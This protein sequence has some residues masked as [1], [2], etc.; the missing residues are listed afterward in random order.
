MT[1]T[2]KSGK[3]SLKKRPQ[4]SL[5]LAESGEQNSTAS[6]RIK[7]KSQ[8]SESESDPE[9]DT[10]FFENESSTEVTESLKQI[11]TD[12]NILQPLVSSIVSAV[13]LTP[14]IFNPLVEAVTKALSKDIAEKL[15]ADLA[16]NVHDSVSVDVHQN[17]KEVD[18]LKQELTTLKNENTQLEKRI[19]D[20]EQYSRR[21]CLLLHGV[22]EDAN[23]D[24]TAVVTD[25]IK[26]KLKIDIDGNDFDRTHRLGRVNPPSEDGKTR[27][28]PIIMRFIS[29]TDRAAVYKEKRHMK[30]S[31]ML[32]S[33]NLTAKRM[34]I[35]RAAY[36]MVKE[37]K[38]ANVWTQDGRI[39]VLTNRKR[40]VII[41]SLADL[42]KL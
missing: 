36:R 4:E 3:L 6:Q 17:M 30:H 34:A 21:N 1:M 32:I 26:K 15:K 31:P 14:N 2:S 38:I 19:D 13:L 7:T 24:T 23:E 29:Y 11:L 22:T 40:K 12:T 8:N 39:T 42:D 41:T 25:I 9:H 28:R 16:Q 37:G 20:A 18:K 10:T 5:N 35:F 33:E 27:P